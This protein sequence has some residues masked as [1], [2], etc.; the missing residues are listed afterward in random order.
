MG[1]I[2]SLLFPSFH[3]SP[4]LK[5][6]NPWLTSA[7]DS[8]LGIVLGGGLLYLTGVLGSF[9]FKKEAMGG[10]D[11]KFLAMVGA[12]WGVKIALFSFLVAP[13]LAVGIGIAY[14]LRTGKSE[15]PYGPFLGLGAFLGIFFAPSF[16]FYAF[17]I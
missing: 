11:V 1:L 9:M 15:I 14:K 6:S 12:F 7:A 3:D 17:G 16:F 4:I 5:F 2:L 8:I 10:G 13:F